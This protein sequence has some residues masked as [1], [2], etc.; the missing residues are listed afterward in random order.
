MADGDQWKVTGSRQ[1]DIGTMSG[2]LTIT[3]RREDGVVQELAFTLAPVGW[4][5]GLRHGKP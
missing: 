1:M 4:D 2:P 5:A 3:V